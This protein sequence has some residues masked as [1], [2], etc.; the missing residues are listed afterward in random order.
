MSMGKNNTKHVLSALKM[1]GFM[2][3]VYSTIQRQRKADVAHTIFRINNHSITQLMHQSTPLQVFQECSTTICKGGP[4]QKWSNYLATMQIDNEILWPHKNNN[5]K[6]GYKMRDNKIDLH[7]FWGEKKKG[8]TQ[9][10][11]NWTDIAVMENRTDTSV[12]C[13]KLTKSMCNFNPN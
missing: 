2:Y 11:S 13:N 8:L 4:S 10:M 12:I 6:W 7:V 3:E 9:M 1:D 5:K